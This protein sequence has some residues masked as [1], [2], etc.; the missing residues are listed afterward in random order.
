MIRITAYLR[1]HRLEEVKS[2]VAALGT[3]GLSVSEARGKGNNPE[4]EVSFAGQTM[5]IA[6][7]VR[8]K[9]EIVV[10]DDLADA[11]VETIISSARSGEPGDGKIFVE[12][13]DD[14]VR[15]RTGEQGPSVI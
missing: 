3:S 5:V 7:P 11:V 8:S 13:I 10:A 14:A 2:A 15:I 9:L 6:L 4:R 1:P 12:K